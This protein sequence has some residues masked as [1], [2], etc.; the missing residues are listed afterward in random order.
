[1]K[2]LSGNTDAGFEA[3]DYLGN[4]VKMFPLLQIKTNTQ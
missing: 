4:K 1:M 2:I 3:L